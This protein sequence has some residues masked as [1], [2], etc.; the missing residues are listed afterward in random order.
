[1]ISYMEEL[2]QFSRE[3]AVD[4]YRRRDER[5]GSLLISGKEIQPFADKH[6]IKL[7]EMEMRSRS[8]L[9]RNAR[10]EYKFSHK[11]VL[12]YFLA[13]EA[14]FN[15]EFRKEFNFESMDQAEAFFDEMIWEKLTLPFFNRSDLNG[16][17]SVKDGKFRVLTKLPAK[18]LPDVTTLKLREWKPDDDVLLFRGLKHLERLYFPTT[19][20]TSKQ[21]DKLQKVL[22]KCKVFRSLR[23][24][25]LTVSEN[26][27]REV[28]G[29]DNDGR[30][31]EYIKNEY[32]DKGE[33]ILDHATGLMWQ[34]SGSED[35]LTY[36]AAQEYVDKPNR[37]KFAGY[38]DWRLPTI[39]ELM[40]LLEPK[41][42]SNGLYINPLFN[43]NQLWCWSCDKRSSSAAWSVDFGDGY[44]DWHYVYNEGYVRVVRA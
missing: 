11:S 35:Y 31:L 21:T 14:F 23:S 9:N 37:K 32:E 41:E 28:F 10:G 8:L 3:I 20:S 17:Y 30:P 39:P 16:E 25:L 38:G 1:M 19:Q 43:R 22:P 15:P 2:Y 4:L 27:F 42:Q 7:S 5:Q 33:V 44:V 13:E 24:K 29:L 18:I 36:K 12:E 40:S 34:K 6:G 26:T